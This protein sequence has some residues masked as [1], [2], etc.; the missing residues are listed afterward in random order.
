MSGILLYNIP[1]ND[2]GLRMRIDQRVTLDQKVDHPV[3][4]FNFPDIKV[5]AYA[6]ELNNGR[7]ECEIFK[8][9]RVYPMRC[10][11]M[12]GFEKLL[13]TVV[14]DETEK[15]EYKQRQKDIKAKNVETLRKN[16]SV[17]TFLRTVFSYNMTFNK[18][19]RVISID[20]NNYQ[21]EVYNNKWV[22][23]GGFTGEVAVGNPT[24]VF[25]TGK[26]TSNGLKIDNLYADITSK[27]ASFY[28]NHL[29]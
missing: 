10:A 17:G 8:G 24:G 5:V 22:S 23:G 25:K 4:K 3:A 27:G 11:T 26:M 21:L 18:F 6:F 16:I 14:K 2:K 12:A 15:K 9:T 1:I 20:K 29:D 28:E 7:I 19:Y 13:M